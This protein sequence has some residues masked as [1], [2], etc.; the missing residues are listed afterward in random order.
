MVY[1]SLLTATLVS[2]LTL[3]GATAALAQAAADNEIRFLSRC[4]PLVDSL[5]A[6]NRC[7]DSLQAAAKLAPDVTRAFLAWCADHAQACEDRIVMVDRA[8]LFR[9]K[10]TCVIRV[11]GSGELPETA[12]SI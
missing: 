3:A 11:R 7:E 2:L 5:E 1:R 8:N 9:A 10:R 12:R 6:F 4:A